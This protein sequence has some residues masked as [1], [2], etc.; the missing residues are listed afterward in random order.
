MVEAANPARL[1]AV[2]ALNIADFD[3]YE[4]ADRNAVR[5]MLPAYLDIIREQVGEN[6]G[7][8]FR[9]QKDSF[10]AEFASPVSAGR[11]AMGILADIAEYNDDQAQ[12]LRMQF[13][14]G[15]H[16]GPASGSGRDLGGEAVNVAES[17]RDIAEPGSICFSHLAYEQSAGR[18]ELEFE[19]LGE[20]DL[21][22]IS[23]PV[24]V[25]K[26]TDGLDM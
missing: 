1:T 25:F 24:T 5:R 15:V 26:G 23:K 11:A 22:G 21:P 9:A 7:R 12:H 3:I 4:K 14:M 2:L 8:L 10:M 19:E 13:C 6:R 17:L 20:R 16:V 18:V